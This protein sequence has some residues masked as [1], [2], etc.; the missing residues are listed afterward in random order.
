[1]ILGKG[2]QIVL[3]QEVIGCSTYCQLVPDLADD[4]IH[5]SVIIMKATK[6]SSKERNYM[7]AAST[8]GM[9]SVVRNQE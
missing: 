8:R 5:F 2:N 3:L 7:I 1:M 9:H 4:Y 6:Q